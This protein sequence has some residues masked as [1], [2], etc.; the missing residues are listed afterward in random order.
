M[1]R[2][3]LAFLVGFMAS[4]WVD[5]SVSDKSSQLTFEPENPASDS[6]P[7]PGRDHPNFIFASFAGLLQ[8]WP[9]TFAY[10]GHSIIPGVV[11]RGTLLYHGTNQQTTP[12]TEGLEWLAFNPEY[13]Y[14]IHSNTNRPVGPVHLY[15]Y[16]ATRTI[17]I[18]YLDGQ[19]SSLGTPGFMDSQSVLINS[20]T[21]PEGFGDEGG[22]I[23][24][25]YE[26]AREL[27]RIGQERGFEGVVRMNTFFELLL[28]DFNQK[29]EL[30]AGTN[31][32]DP[33]DTL[34]QP[35]EVTGDSPS[36]SS[37]TSAQNQSDV[38]QSISPDEVPHQLQQAINDSNNS[39]IHAKN[40]RESARDEPQKSLL[41]LLVRPRPIKSPFFRRSSQYSF[42]ASSRQFFMPGEVR[43]IL[44]PS[45]FVSFYDRVESLSQKRQADGSSQSPRH[46]HRLFGISSGDMDKIKDRL[47]NVL[48][49][50]NAEGWRTDSDRL[51]WRAT[52]WTIVQTYS[53]P[54]VE[55]D[56]LLKR[57]DLTA[58]D[59]AAEV[60]DLTYGML[61]PYVDFSSWNVSDPAWKDQT[62]KK[63]R[64]GFTAGTYRASEL[65][66]SLTVIIG[67]IEGT[68]DRLCSTV[69]S[70]FSKTIKLSIPI[71]SSNS[72]NSKWERVAQWRTSEWR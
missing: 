51:D 24:A 72:S 52:A 47:F 38:A 25:E 49:R 60:R 30:L 18:I 66:E 46:T 71:H 2:L 56:Y 22:Y 27:C 13:S 7:S 9:N 12:P 8:Q 69:L 23:K 41:Q 16:A 14:V 4:W 42:R 48:A 6:S 68:L 57:D 35:G 67:A 33:Y 53:N 44:D 11:P 70:I 29:V 37:A 5:P 20:T 61:I 63:C 50:K 26:R 21:V 39:T 34:Y 59:R 19:S 58:I 62:I 17:R 64:R 54:L 43:V 55:L 15:T 40:H 3:M 65:T 1:K 28:C 10:S 45:G 31:T 36:E 32:T